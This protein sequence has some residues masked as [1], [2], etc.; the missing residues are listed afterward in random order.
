MEKKLIIGLS[1]LVGLLLVLNLVKGDKSTGQVAKQV[2]SQQKTQ[3]TPPQ[4]L[5]PPQ[6]QA[7]PP[8]PLQPQSIPQAPQDIKPEL[9][10]SAI[11]EKKEEKLPSPVEETKQ[12][13]KQEVKQ[14][15]K[16]E[17][18]EEKKGIK[19]KPQPQTTPAMDKEEKPSQETAMLEGYA[20]VCV[21][22]GDCALYKDGKTIKKGSELDG[23][24]VERISPDGV[25]LRRGE[26]VR[27]VR[28]Q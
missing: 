18:K 3:A 24:I 13:E 14:K 19:R 16:Q 26:Q 20:L 2:P 27:K 5:P 15:I 1:L 7:L 12:Q 4:A 9:P 22:G 11:E 10:P 25:E 21:I 28:V 8:Q 17:K 23:W 6:P